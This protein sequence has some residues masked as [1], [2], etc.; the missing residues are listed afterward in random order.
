MVCQ[1]AW[2]DHESGVGQDGPV[3]HE[4]FDSDIARDVQLG[5]IE[6]RPGGEHSGHG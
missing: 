4:L 6:S 1:P 2:V 5:R 3:W